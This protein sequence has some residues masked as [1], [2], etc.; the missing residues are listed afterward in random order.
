MIVWPDKDP[1]DTLE[2]GMDFSDVFDSDENVLSVAWV[3]PTGI[4]NAGEKIS[5]QICTVTISGG[6]LDTTYTVTAQ[7]TTDKGAPAH[8]WERDARLRVKN[9]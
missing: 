3:F 7:V 9:L 2:F 5:G 1:G 6:S 4:S 8:I